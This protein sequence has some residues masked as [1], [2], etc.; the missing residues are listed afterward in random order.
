LCHGAKVDQSI[1]VSLAKRG[2]GTRVDG[3]GERPVLAGG[4]RSSLHGRH[5]RERA[6]LVD[7]LACPAPPMPQLGPIAFAFAL[8]DRTEAEAVDELTEAIGG[9]LGGDLGGALLALNT[10]SALERISTAG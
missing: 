3:G 2:H 4:P 1:D 6:I 9:A 7:E 10:R 5:V 8:L